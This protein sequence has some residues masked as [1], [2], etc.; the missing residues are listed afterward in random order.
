[1]MTVTGEYLT[2][3]GGAPSLQALAHG[4]AQMPRY[5]GQTLF[6]WYVADHLVVCAKIAKNWMLGWPD[7]LQLHAL[8]HDAHEAMTGDI[9]VPFKTPDMKEL[10][11]ALDGRIYGR[12][13]LP[14]LTPME[15]VAVKAIDEEAL[16][17]EAAVVCPPRTYDK[18]I[19]ERGHEANPFL[20][21]LVEEHMHAGFEPEEAWLEAVEPLVLAYSKL[22][23]AS[24]EEI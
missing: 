16:L 9:P 8:L 6:H 10:Q 22:R 5:A 11:K 24:R 2:L 12:F 15:C 18:I 19:Y 14:S 20:V 23:F 4:L 21:K 7:R 17:A 13:G 3:D 1:M